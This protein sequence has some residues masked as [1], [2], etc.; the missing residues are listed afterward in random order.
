MNQLRKFFFI[1]F[2]L[3]FF[4][5]FSQRTTIY[6][7]PSLE[8]KNGIELFDK[9]LF[10]SAQTC[11]LHILESN[12][13]KNYLIRSDAEFFA[14]AC[15]IELFHKDGEWRFRNFIANYPE[16]NRIKWAY[17]YLGKSNY[18]KKKYSEVIQWLEKVEIGRA[19]V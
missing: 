8:Y 17:F 11:F 9:K 7:D 3:G 4:P 16:S 14:A 10:N 5:G 15:A 6:L 2:F 12:K 1:S 13:D 19:H 18:R